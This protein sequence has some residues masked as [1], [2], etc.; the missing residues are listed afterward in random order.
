LRCL[1]RCLA[2]EYSGIPAESHIVRDADAIPAAKGVGDKYVTWVVLH[3]WSNEKTVDI[4]KSVR[5]AFGEHLVRLRV[6]ILHQSCQATSK[7]RSYMPAAWHLAS[8]AAVHEQLPKGAAREI[9]EGFSVA[10]TSLLRCCPIRRVA[11]GR[12][13]AYSTIDV[14]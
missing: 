4:L 14:Q 8:A 12:L 9:L 3:D 7:S 5:E 6:Y 1:A 13:R 2:F 10:F 11:C